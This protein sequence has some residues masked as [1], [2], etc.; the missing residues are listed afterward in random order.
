MKKTVFIIEDDHEL[1]DLLKIRLESLGH[2]AL[3]CDNGEEA[4]NS[5][6]KIKPDLIILDI[7]LA[8]MDGLTVLKRS[9]AEVDIVTGE[10]SEIKDIPVIV[11]T[12]K[13]PMVESMTR[14]E[15]AVDFF[16]KPFDTSKLLER[17]Y[18]VLHKPL[19]KK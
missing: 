7:F 10:P 15:G 1:V 5:V 17:I 2:K 4:L 13:A 14:L 18:E 3:S 12:G 9:K 19:E 6:E 8:D 16:V 11:I